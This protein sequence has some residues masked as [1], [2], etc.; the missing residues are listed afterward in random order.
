MEWES[1][2]WIRLD[3]W[4]DSKQVIMSTVINLRVHKMRINSYFPKRLLTYKKGISFMELAC[5]LLVNLV[6]WFQCTNTK[7][8]YVYTRQDFIMVLGFRILRLENLI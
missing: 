3:Q 8:T 2:V 6:K 5:L 1:V 7:G 4:K